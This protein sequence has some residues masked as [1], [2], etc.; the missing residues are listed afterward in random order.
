MTAFILPSASTMASH[1]DALFHFLLVTCG[2]ALAIIVFGK[3]FFLFRFHRSRVEEEKS[4]YITG[5]TVTEAG[6]AV[7]LTIW[8]MF[9]FWWG[10]TDYKALR[11]APPGAMEIHVTGRQWSWEALY[12]DGRRL[13][14]EL[15]VPVGRPVKLLMTSKDVLHS[16]FVPAFRVKQDVIP[17]VYTSLWFEAT[18]EGE[19]PVYCAEYCGDAHSA[20][21][22]KVRVLEPHAFEAW[23]MAYE[24]EQEKEPSGE[25]ESAK[26]E[27]LAKQGEALFAKSGCVACHSLEGKKVIGPQL[28]GIFGTEVEL[29]DGQKVSIDENYLRESILEPNAKI[30]KGFAPM[31]PTMKGQLQESEVTALITYIKSFGG[32]K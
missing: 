30:V 14:N 19:Y 25:G 5:H 2:V 24:L 32:K 1:V 28:N 22:A 29:A 26:L 3:L 16:F 18:K 23:A 13:T 6:V 15:V 10:W 17:N 12:D 9:I 20:M 4:S 31:M 21:L 8:V 27:G 7:L 11:T